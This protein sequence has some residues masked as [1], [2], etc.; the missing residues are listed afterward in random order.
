MNP[1]AIKNTGRDH[2]LSSFIWLFILVFTSFYPLVSF[3]QNNTVQ[4]EQK[5]QQLPDDTARVNV[6][7]KLGEQFCSEDND[8]ALMY[9]QEAYTISTSLD[10]TEGIG[11]SL[12]WL[13][14]VYYY[15]SNFNL[16]NKYL[17]KAK[18]RLKLSVIRGHLLFGTWLKHSACVQMATTQVL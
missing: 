12:M 9:L 17:D 15:K 7:L 16:S 5:L 13:G 10:Y 11:K 6:L 14:R 3:T 1:K 4:L 2:F 8:K 18:N